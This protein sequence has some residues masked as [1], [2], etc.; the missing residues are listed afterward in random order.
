[1]VADDAHLS[2]D[3]SGLAGMIGDPRFDSVTV[4][5]TVAAGAAAGVLARLG[6]G[7][8]GTAVIQLAGLA[9]KEIG[10]IVAGHGFT[11]EAFKSH[12]V[13]VAQ[14]SPWLAHAA[15]LIAS[16]RSVY[17]WSDTAELL[18]QLVDQRLRQDGNSQTSSHATSQ[19]AR[20][21]SAQRWT[22]T[23][24]PPLWHSATQRQRR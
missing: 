7:R 20:A 2:P 18:G 5:L 23:Q 24:P 8:R 22:T 4:V 10:E 12:V 17:S 16:E 15:C 19:Q 6:V 13:E 21:S 1:M 9:R 14:G 3:L 11:G